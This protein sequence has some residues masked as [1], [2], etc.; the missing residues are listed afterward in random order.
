MVYNGEESKKIQI[1]SKDCL[2]FLQKTRR[3]FV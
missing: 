3:V 1:D 2:K